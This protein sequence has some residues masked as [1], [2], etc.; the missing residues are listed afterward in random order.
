[1]ISWVGVGGG[2]AGEGVQLP[3]YGIV[4]MCVPNG[5][6]FQSFQ[7]Y[8]WPCFFNKKYMN[9]PIFLDS[10]FWYPSIY[11]YFFPQIFFETACSLGSQWIDCDICLTTSN[12]W[13]Q[14]VKGQHFW[15]SSKWMAPFFSK[16]RYMN[17]VGFEILARTPVPQLPPS[18]PPPPPPTPRAD[19]AN[20][21]MI[22]PPFSKWKGGVGAF[23]FRQSGSKTTGGLHVSV[24]LF[25]TQLP[26]LPTVAKLD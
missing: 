20:K 16:A 23:F 3:I 1:M 9:D 7:V 6:L 17:G 21:G 26:Q 15:W 22:L 13:V 2:G 12:K 5:P 4:W 18:Y 24:S 19:D 8:H 11:T 14:K 25:L 10:L